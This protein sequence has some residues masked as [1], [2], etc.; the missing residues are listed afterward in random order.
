MNAI[1]SENN[2]DDFLTKSIKNR[3]NQTL[4]LTYSNCLKNY[5]KGN[6]QQKRSIL[7]SYNFMKSINQ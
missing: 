3:P 1:V 6:L 4:R 7:W 2:F 5:K